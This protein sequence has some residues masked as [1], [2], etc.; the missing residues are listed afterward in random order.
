MSVLTTFLSTFEIPGT[1]LSREIPVKRRNAS[2]QSYQKAYLTV[3]S[4]GLMNLMIQM[5]EMMNLALVEQ[6]L[7][8]AA[9]SSLQMKEMAQAQA[10]SALVMAHS[11]IRRTGH[12]TKAT[13]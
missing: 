2:E 8:V 12:I 1:F 5:T 7:L 4:Q 6:A 10:D 9:T 13:I 3:K 11:H